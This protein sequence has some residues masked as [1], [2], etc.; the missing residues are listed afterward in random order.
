[1]KLIILIVIVVIGVVALGPSAEEQ[2]TAFETKLNEIISSQPSN[3][4]SSGELAS[5]FGIMSDHTDLQRDNKEKEIKGKLVD[6]TLPVFEVHN[7]K[8]NTYK[9]QTPTR[10]SIV[11]AFVIITTRSPEEVSYVEGLKTGDMIRIKGVITGTF[12]RNIEI[13]PAVIIR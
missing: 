13:E 10:S 7:I 11:G 5:I 12:M 6:W 2:A 8:E 4:Q 1:M 3:L 9:I